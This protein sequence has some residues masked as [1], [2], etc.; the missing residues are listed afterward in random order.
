MIRKGTL[1]VL[2]LLAGCAGGEGP[3]RVVEPRAATAPAP[4]NDAALK[5]AMLDG[6]NAARAAVG[7]PA[8][9]WDDQLAAHAAAYA[10]VLAKTRQFRHAEQ[11]NGPGREGE[12]LFTGTRDAYSYPEMVG[13]WVAEKKDFVNRSA[14][15][16]SRTGRGEDV[17]HYT[18]IVWRTTTRFGCALASSK[19]D[20]YLVC[21]YAPAGNII[22]VKAF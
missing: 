21:R 12:N 2:V 17:G 13:L 16:V 10:A 19:T 11:P 4:R 8:L 3:E 5:K 9:V 18:Q 20:D 14:P 6:H 1:G 7:V 22:G 15:D